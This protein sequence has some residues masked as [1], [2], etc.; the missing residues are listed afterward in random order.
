MEE[1]P[2]SLYS[3][4]ETME[5]ARANELNWTLPAIVMAYFLNHFQV[6]SINVFNQKKEKVACFLFLAHV[7]EHRRVH[8]LAL[9]NIFFCGALAVFW[10]S[11]TVQS[12]EKETI[13]K[14]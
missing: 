3:N 6:A 11:T 5:N 8:I 4:G 7:P 1:V 10:D 9:K 13:K 14:I 2:L 12:V